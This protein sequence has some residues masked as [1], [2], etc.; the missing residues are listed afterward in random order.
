MDYSEIPLY[1]LYCSQEK[2]TNLI[3]KEIADMTKITLNE[4]LEQEL[5]MQEL[6]IRDLQKEGKTEV[7]IEDIIE[8]VHECV[9]LGFKVT[10]EPSKKYHTMILLHKNNSSQVSA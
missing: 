6:H 2:L 10:L 7:H 4:I 1:N 5:T 8:V 3:D 9:S